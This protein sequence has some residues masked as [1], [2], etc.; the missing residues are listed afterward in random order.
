M[1][2][3]PDLASRLSAPPPERSKVGGVC[4]LRVVACPGLADRAVNPYT[5]L[6][7]EPMTRRGCAVSEFSFYRA[8]PADTDVLHIHWPERIFWGR[9]SRAHP[10]LSRLYAGRMLRQ[11]DRVRSHGGIVVWTAHNIAPHEPLGES[12]ERIWRAY[13]AAFCAKVDLVINLTAEAERRCHDAYP[14]LAGAES[15]VI[16]HPHYRTAYPARVDT[17]RARD[18]LGIGASDFILAAVGAIRPGKGVLELAQAFLQVAREDERLVIAGACDDT[19]YLSALVDLAGGSAGRLIVRPHRL[20]DDEM[21][22]IYSA[23]DLGAFNFKQILNSGSVL[24]SL[25]YDVPVCAP[26]L[27]SLKA[28]SEELGRRWFVPLPQPLSP[29][30]LRET[31]DV[32]RAERPRRGTSAP[33]GAYDPESLSART[34]AAYRNCLARVAKARRP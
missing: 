26:E 24:L 10:R 33:L 7:H 21:A 31:L 34:L 2:I 5:W 17:A 18:A 15:V 32:A 9:V 30:G 25:S 20:S 12:R 6:V 11:I 23:A 19:A 1:S 8:C 14:E 22:A 29:K 27:G 16:P 28:L 4:G 3:A 13:M